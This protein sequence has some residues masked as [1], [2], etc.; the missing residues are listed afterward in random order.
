MDTDCIL[1]EHSLDSHGYGKQKYGGKI[2]GAHVLA[3]MAYN[4]PVPDGKQIN[5]HCD[6]RRCINPAHLYA[7]TPKQNMADRRARGRA[8]NGN[9]DKTHCKNGHEF[10]EE[11]TFYRGDGTGRRCRT[12]DRAREKSEAR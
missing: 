2:K 9:T 11:N 6:V 7:G 1:W 3:W 8:R 12:C 10:T 5:H 4:G